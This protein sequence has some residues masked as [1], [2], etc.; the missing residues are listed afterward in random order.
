MNI[1]YILISTILYALSFPKFNLWWFSF[2]SL[3]PF[4]FALDNADSPLKNLLYGV[5]WSAGHAFGMGYWVFFT[6]L[7][8]YE[9][10]FAKSVLFFTLCVI[11]PV[12]LIFTVFAVFYRF[13]HR[14]R[15]FF[16]A[17]VVP[18]LWV[19]AEYLKEV[20]SFLIP[21]GGI[22]YALIPFSEFIQIADLTGGYGI[23]FIAVS[24]NSLFVYMLKQLKF[25]KAKQVTHDKNH[26][27]PLGISGA[28]VLIPLAL[29]CLLMAIPSVYGVH[30]LRKIGLSVGQEY[31]A[32]Q[33]V[34][35]TLVQGN[36]STKERWSG[37]GFYQRVMNYLEMSVEMP[38]ET[39]GDEGQGGERVIVWPET[40]LNSSS[41][42]ND[43]LFVELMRNIGENSLLISGGLKTDHNSNEVFN[44]A[45]FISGTGRLLRYDKH[46]LLPYSETSPL[47]DLLD[48]Y[49]SAP[50]EFTA[51]R[52]PLCI[53]AP[54]GKVGASICFEILYSG[55][56][57]QSVKDGAQYLVNIS[58]DSWFGDSPMPY[59]H[60][61]AARLRAVENRRFLLRTSNSGI[62]AVISPNGKV[63]A[64]SG[65]FTKERIDGDFV[66]FDQL[67]FYAMY[68]NLILLG[69]AIILLTALIQVII[70]KD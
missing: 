70:K 40:T 46:I 16:Y 1:F 5:L 42:L 12:V 62:S 30:Q 18:S 51:G 23:M 57:R 38:I 65:L 50:N 11:I 49:Y 6:I 20:A 41:K 25:Q 59:I 28:G 36:Y 15:L 66:K 17:L 67:S 29:I 58:N 47:I 48:A 54:G 24:V 21:W 68:G 19:L 60:L 39:I 3:V 69:S 35:T 9:V 33:S 43:A 55:F 27:N 45:Y 56:I 37:M 34:Q 14:E 2:V 7:N 53:N 4:F 32:G 64:Q 13:L 31:K 52:T 63:I 8:H 26:N 22:E 44:S 61:N 10:P